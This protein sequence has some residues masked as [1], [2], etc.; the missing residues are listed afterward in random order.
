MLFP[1][2]LLADNDETFLQ[3][4]REF[5]ES[6]GYQVICATTSAAAKD[7]LE[8]VPIALAILD[9][10]L[11]NDDDER[12]KSGLKLA[13]ETMNLNVPKIILTRFD[14]YEYAVESLRPG[15]EGTVAI[16]FVV[17][18][19]GLEKLLDAVE[20]TLTKARVFLCYANPDKEK[21]L[22]LYN[23]LIGVGFAPWMDKK[24]LQGGERWEGAIRRTIR[25]SDFF[26][27][28]LSNKSV[29]RRGFMQ[30][31]I[32]FALDVWDE[33]LEDDIYMIPARLEDCVIT[34]E[35]LRELQWVDLFKPD[36]FGRLVQAIR[37]GT[38]RRFQQA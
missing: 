7:I 38:R 8:N 31:E 14:K 4:A 26:V 15:K 6:R 13:Q 2:I 29:N 30:R 17:K 10:R 3:N 12:D 32:R 34:H 19:D 37:T 23:A 35:K 24:Q 21:I 36:G 1:T 25:T 9:Y 20:R 11:D 5:I 33:K 16:D 22:S 18:Q 27:V 28:C